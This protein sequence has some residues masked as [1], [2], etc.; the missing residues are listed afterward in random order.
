M[1]IMPD[2]VVQAAPITTQASDTLL[3]LSSE[4]REPSCYQCQHAA[5]VSTTPE[6]GQVE[7]GGH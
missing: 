6:L 2:A 1:T 5:L 3:L 4:Y 7:N